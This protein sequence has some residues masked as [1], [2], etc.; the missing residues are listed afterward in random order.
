MTVASTA[1]GG[2][3]G[4]TVAAGDGITITGTDTKTIAVT[5]PFTD[6]DESKLDGIEAGAQVNPARAGA[7]TAADEAKLDGIEAGA[8]VNAA[9]LPHS[10]SFSAQDN[11][12]SDTINNGSIG[13]FNGSTQIQSGSLGAMTH[14]Y[15][16]SAAATYGQDPTS[17]GTDLDAVSN[18]SFLND[19]V[20]GK[21]QVV[22]T[23]ARQGT[24]TT[25]E[26]VGG[27]VATHT[28][29]YVLTGL[30]IQDPLSV[31]GS[32]Y[33]WNVSIRRTTVII[34]N[35]I[36]GDI[37]WTKIDGVPSRVGTFTAEDET[38]LDALVAERTLHWARILASRQRPRWRQDSSIMVQA[39]CNLY[40]RRAMMFIRTGTLERCSLWA[41]LGSLW[42]RA[43]PR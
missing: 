9:P 5:N 1:S 33:A 39:C 25:M 27:L 38:N 37:A 42:Q 31:T 17:P 29:G 15:I 36:V 12:T 11:D 22:V 28:G 6:A 16:P 24:N 21:C 2:G 8:Q 14:L 10:L 19:C 7:F 32:G 20:T 23:I 4:D 34:A 40:Q 3:S 18:A 30:V 26:V 13:F 43:H 35:Q 41:M